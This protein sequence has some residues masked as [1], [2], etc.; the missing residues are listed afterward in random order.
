MLCQLEV[1]LDAT[2]E[3][4]RLARAAGVLTVLTPA[5][6]AE[7]PEELFGLCDL[8]VPNETEVELLTGRPAGDVGGA[9][10]LRR[11]GVGAVVV[12]LGSR[13]ALLL[14]GDGAT[15]LPAVPVVA[16]DPTGA[17]DAFA[18]GLA[19]FR[20]EGLAL[21]EAA[22]RASVVAALTVTRLG[23]QVAFPTRAEVADRLV[24]GRG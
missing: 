6:A 13:G 4:F 8:C 20:A 24:A 22:R 21:R 9:E 17:G 5:P 2:L 1:P 7:L 14:D 12:T 16:V 11:R 3:A 19:V 18:A 15:H 23:T 10:A